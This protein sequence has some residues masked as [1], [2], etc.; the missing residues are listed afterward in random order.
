MLH[1]GVSGIGEYTLV[2]VDHFR[3]VPAR[4][5]HRA[6]SVQC[7]RE[8]RV[9]FKVSL[10]NLG[11][12]EPRIA[13]WVPDKRT[14]RRPRCDEGVYRLASDLARRSSDQY[15]ARQ[16]PRNSCDGMVTW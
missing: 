12:A 1:F 10:H 5:Q 9:V 4:K 14:D 13:G 2:L 7:A 8:G 6:D 11:A 3:A 15:H 16:L